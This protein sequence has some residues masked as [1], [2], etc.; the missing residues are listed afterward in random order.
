M[1]AKLISRSAIGG[2][3]ELP[4]AQEAT[5][6]KDAANS[7]VLYEKNI[8]K[9]HARIFFDAAENCYVLEDLNSRNGT[10]LDGERVHG[11]ER[12]DNVHIITLGN[13]FEFFFQVVKND[14]KP[15]DSET[16]ETRPMTL[17]QS[18]VIENDFQDVQN[19][20]TV[21]DD[22][23]VET[24][25]FLASAGPAP[26]I[27]SNL[28]EI[29]AIDS[30]LGDVEERV[31]SQEVAMPFEEETGTPS[32]FTLTI[33]GLNQKYRLKQGENIVGR[34]SR[35][36]I[37]IKHK[38]VSRQH[39]C[40][41]VQNDKIQIHDLNSKNHTFVGRRKVLHVAEITTR[42][43]LRFGEVAAVLKKKYKE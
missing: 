4:I 3:H 37:A 11:K 27:N 16:V 19:S 24:P 23:F 41:S 31:V 43:F 8:S 28:T 39:A 35:C 10:R 29:K 33:E 2:A 6:G 30:F 1:Q 17:N 9:R 18:T 40:I 21:F 36:D 34:S 5:I 12:L 15:V 14:S 32:A 26:S 7:I 22:G 25:E 20:K 13:R 38:T 42:A